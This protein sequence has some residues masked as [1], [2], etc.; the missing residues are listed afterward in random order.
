MEF[1]SPLSDIYTDQKEFSS[2]ISQAKDCQLN[3]SMKKIDE[4]KFLDDEIINEI[5]PDGAPEAL[6]SKRHEIKNVQ[7]RV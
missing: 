3:Y 1:L 4:F 2:L 6:L 5:M 7:K